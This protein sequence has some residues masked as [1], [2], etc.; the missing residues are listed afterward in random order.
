MKKTDKGNKRKEE[1]R[2]QRKA[3]LEWARAT[4]RQTMLRNNITNQK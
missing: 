1:T 3:R 2:R 4:V